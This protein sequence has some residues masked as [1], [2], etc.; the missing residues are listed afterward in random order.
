VQ[1][2]WDLGQLP[3]DALTPLR[4]S[5]LQSITLLTSPS[6]P[7]GARAILVQVCLAV[8]D[9][10]LQMPEWDN[11]VGSM[12]DRF[13]KEES[14]VNVMLQFLKCLVEEAANPR[15]PMAVSG[16]LQARGKWANL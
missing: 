7:T 5:L 4:D 12:I 10:A 1:I 6:A 8:S 9:L 13:G 3:R 16:L 14:T 2:L 15:V 11:V